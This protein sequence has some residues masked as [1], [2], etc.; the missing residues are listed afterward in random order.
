M[1]TDNTNQQVPPVQNIEQSQSAPLPNP[2]SHSKIFIIITTVILLTIIGVGI[3]VLGTRKNQPAIQNLQPTSSPT[4]S[5]SS[6]TNDINL[7]STGSAE[8]A[9]WKTY[10]D[11][12][13]QYSVRYPS[14]WSIEKYSREYAFVGNSQG[15]KIFSEYQKSHKSNLYITI[16]VEKNTKNL[17]LDDFLNNYLLCGDAAAVDNKCPKGEYGTK[18]VIAGLLGRKLVNPPGPIASEQVIVLK[19]DKIFSFF[20]PT[21]QLNDDAYSFQDKEAYFDQILSTFKFTD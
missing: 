2:S 13:N 12:E 21:A 15:I 5:H 10:T 18:I 8:T 4:A 9:N 3:Y 20:V 6:P 1:G 17:S 19:S 16:E 11:V 14:T 7:E